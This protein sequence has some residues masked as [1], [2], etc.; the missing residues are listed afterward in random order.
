[1]LV[2]FAILAGVGLWQLKER[3]K[4]KTMSGDGGDL[5][6]GEKVGDKVGEGK[7]EGEKKE[8]EMGKKGKKD[9]ESTCKGCEAEKS[10]KGKE[11]VGERVLKVLD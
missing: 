8:M 3:K 6:M 1:M 10:G 7:R 2:L 9:L 5:E 11:V 4:E